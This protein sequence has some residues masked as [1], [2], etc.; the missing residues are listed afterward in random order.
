M[1]VIPERLDSEPADGAVHH[2]HVLEL[3]LEVVPAELV[4]DDAVHHGHG[5]ER[6][7]RELVCQM[8]RD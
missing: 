1:I 2:V 7:V 5:L 6:E 3:V 4:I 8:R